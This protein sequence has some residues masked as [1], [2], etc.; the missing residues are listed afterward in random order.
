MTIYLTK[1]DHY[2]HYDGRKVELWQAGKYFFVEI[3]P[4][5]GNPVTK[6]FASY[7]RAREAYDAAVRGC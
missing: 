5:R 2:T 3:R 6:N 7:T 1:L 4:V